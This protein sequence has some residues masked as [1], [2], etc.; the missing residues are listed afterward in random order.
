MKIQIDNQTI[1]ITANTTVITVTHDSVYDRHNIIKNFTHKLNFNFNDYPKHEQK[2]KEKNY[3]EYMWLGNLFNDFLKRK[4][5]IQL[6]L[7]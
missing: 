2:I 6:K 3:A 4:Q 1:E 5:V 7:F